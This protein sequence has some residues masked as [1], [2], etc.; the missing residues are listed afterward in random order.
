MQ[1]KRYRKYPIIGILIAI[2]AIIMLPSKSPHRSFRDYEDIQTEGI[3]RITTNYSTKS[4]YVNDKGNI[5]GYHYQLA[6]QFADIHN[7]KLE[8]IPLTS[9]IEQEELLRNGGCDII[10]NGRPLSIL[11]DTFFR[12]T[13]P[14]DINR[15]ILIQRRPL[16]STDS[17][18]YY[19]KSQIDLAGRTL[20]IPAGSTFRNRIH[21]LIEEIGDTIY[22]HEMPLYG[23]EQLMAMVAHGDIPYAICDEKTVKA[24]IHQYPQLDNTLAFG[25]NQ[26]YTWIVNQHSTALLDSLNI[27]IPRLQENKHIAKEK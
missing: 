4:Y 15:Q 18:Q 26:F 25:F 19:L 14:V 17:T 3:L 24:Y 22:I 2:S 20:T 6:K 13:V 9:Y 5:D 27:W 7:L 1:W 16:T 12:H 21:H 11:P 23:E 10:I 8:V